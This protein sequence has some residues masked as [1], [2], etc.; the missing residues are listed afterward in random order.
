MATVN[1]ECRNCQR[2]TPDGKQRPDGLTT[3]NCA[4]DGTGRFATECCAS[5]KVYTTV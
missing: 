2:W 4:K 3:G 5:F 1:R